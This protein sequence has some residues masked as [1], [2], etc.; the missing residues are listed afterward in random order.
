MPGVKQYD[1]TSHSFQLPKQPLWEDIKDL[2]KWKRQLIY[3][4]K[5]R[6]TD[7]LNIYIYHQ[8][9]TYVFIRLCCCCNVLLEL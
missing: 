6:G 8:Y 4:S 5:Q 3:R 7:Q 9:A 1:N 2:D